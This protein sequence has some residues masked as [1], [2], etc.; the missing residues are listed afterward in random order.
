[1]GHAPVHLFVRPKKHAI[2]STISWRN[3]K[4]SRFHFRLGISRRTKSYWNHISQLS[5]LDPMKPTIFAHFWIF[6]K[7]YGRARAASRWF[8]WLPGEHLQ[9][10][11]AL[12]TVQGS[13][14]EAVQVV[15]QSAQNVDAEPDKAHMTGDRGSCCLV[16]VYIYTYIYI[17]IYIFDMIFQVVDFFLEGIC[18]DTV[19]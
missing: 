15:D 12:T 19:V 8:R 9:M 3:T 7:P 18:Y 11:M 14:Q 4:P 1:M 17:Y 10:T 6:S 16:Y 2:S 13:L 5:S